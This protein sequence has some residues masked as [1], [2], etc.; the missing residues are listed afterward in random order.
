MPNGRM[1]RF[2]WLG[3]EFVALQHLLHDSKGDEWKAICRRM[4]EVYDQ[5]VELMRVLEQDEP[6]PTH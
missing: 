5:Q 4:T 3:R 1:N 2:R 6:C